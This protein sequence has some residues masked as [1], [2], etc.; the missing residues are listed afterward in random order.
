HVSKYDSEN[1]MN[2]VVEK[3]LSE[4]AFWHLDVVLHY[5]LRDLLKDTALLS[6][7]EYRYAMNSETHTDFLIFNKL[8]KLPVYVVEEN[9]H[10]FH[11]KN[12]K[13][14][15]RDQMK[16]EIH[17]KYQ[18]PIVRMKTTGSEEAKVLREK[19]ENIEQ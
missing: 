2:M 18:I 7:E 9:C 8:N 17:N 5:P 12:P 16:D 13:Q 3:V 6:D 19:L 4:E 1:L 15:K 10:E 11:A 14:L